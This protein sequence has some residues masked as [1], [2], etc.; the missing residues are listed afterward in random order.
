M[1]LGVLASQSVTELVESRN[2]LKHSHTQIFVWIENCRNHQNTV[3]R[4]PCLL[5]SVLYAYISDM[6]AGLF[7]SMLL[8]YKVFMNSK[9]NEYNMY[10]YA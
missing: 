2:S 5:S 9:E 7:I 1:K 3:C 4:F 10:M 8:Y 6:C